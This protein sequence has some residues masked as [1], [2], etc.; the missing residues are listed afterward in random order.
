MPLKS[1]YVGQAETS[2]Q[3]KVFLNSLND[4]WNKEIKSHALLKAVFRSNLCN[5][6]PYFTYSQSALFDF[7]LDSF[8]WIRVFICFLIQNVRKELFPYRERKGAFYSKRRHWLVSI[9][10]NR[11]VFQ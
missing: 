5:I 8:C 9:E 2:H 11:L 4:I 6:F 1:E 3:S 10:I 7:F